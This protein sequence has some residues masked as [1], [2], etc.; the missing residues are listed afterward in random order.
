MQGSGSGRLVTRLRNVFHACIQ[1]FNH[2]A[3]WSRLILRH[4]DS[5]RKLSGQKWLVAPK[6]LDQGAAS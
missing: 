2:C 1:H 4:M 5:R 6:R 3:E